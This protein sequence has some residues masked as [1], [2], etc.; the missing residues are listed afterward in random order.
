MRTPRRGRYAKHAEALRVALDL[1][2]HQR[3]GLV[4]EL[5]DRL[6]QGADLEVP[7]GAGDHFD[8]AILLA[9]VKERAEAIVFVLH[10]VSSICLGSLSRR[11]PALYC[12]S[13]PV[14]LTTNC[15]RATS[16]RTRSA[17]SSAFSLLIP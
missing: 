5:G 7:V 15:H 13:I 3:R 9:F 1:V 14:S 16:D 4:D 10:I 8:L 17:N 12:C 11:H 2:E 6:S